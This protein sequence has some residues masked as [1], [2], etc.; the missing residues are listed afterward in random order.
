MMR[1][2]RKEKNELLP[3]ILRFAVGGLFLWFGIDKWIRPEAWYGYVP[4]WL[5]GRLPFELDTFMYMNG[6]FEFAVGLLLVSGKLVREASAAAGL[7]LVAIFF[8]MGMNEVTVRDNAV[9]GA[10]LAL[11]VDANSRAKKPLQEKTV[12]MLVSVYV[13]YIFVGGLLFLKKG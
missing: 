13:F 10:C 8:T 3:V 11:F 9:L 12:S 7:F 6:I 1:L 2:F 5:L 4:A